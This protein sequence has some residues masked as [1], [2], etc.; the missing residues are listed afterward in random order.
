MCSAVYGL[1][2]TQSCD[3]SNRALAALTA[4]LPSPPTL[5]SLHVHMDES[6]FPFAAQE[7]GEKEEK[8]EVEMSGAC[9]VQLVTGLRRMS[10]NSANQTQSTQVQKTLQAL[11]PFV[12]FP[13]CKTG[14]TGYTHSPLAGRELALVLSNIRTWDF[15]LPPVRDFLSAL[16]SRSAVGVDIESIGTGTQPP[17]TGIATETETEIETR[18]AV[19]KISKKRENSNSNSLYDRDRDNHYSDTHYSDSYHISVHQFVDGLFAFQGGGKEVFS[20]PL[21]RGLLAAL[22]ARAKGST[23]DVI[24]EGGGI[25][26]TGVDIENIILSDASSTGITNDPTTKAARVGITKGRPKGGD[27]TTKAA[28]AAQALVAGEE[29]DSI[30]R[31]TRDALRHIDPQALE[32]KAILAALTGVFMVHVS[33]DKAKVLLPLLLGFFLLQDQLSLNVNLIGR[34][35]DCVV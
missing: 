32:V 28:Q 14:Y 34:V 19:N 16:L 25:L 3:S 24:D 22:L 10:L 18:L 27:S 7:K 2:N 15:S 21:A 20:D 33:L 5:P 11:T 26:D 35:L 29:A 31:S 23:G 6:A 30:T 13:A 4:L 1:K 9:I 12:Y 17:A 8:E